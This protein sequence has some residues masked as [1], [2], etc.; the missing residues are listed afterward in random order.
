MCHA[1]LDG[2]TAQDGNC[3]VSMQAH[4]L[5]SVVLELVGDVLA[6]A[7]ADAEIR[8]SLRSIWI[9]LS[10]PNDDGTRRRTAELEKVTAEAKT[11]LARAAGMLVDGN[12]DKLGYEAVRDQILADVEAANAELA[13]LRGKEVP[14]SLPDLDTV[15]RAV[16]SWHRE[17]RAADVGAQ[18]D[19][20]APIVD[21]IV[22]RR[23]GWGKYEAD[24]AWSPLGESL[25]ALAQAAR[26]NRSS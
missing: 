2:A 18:R 17:L 16:E 10:R 1:P 14:T 19:V 9:A 25:H 15:L 11:R 21:R 20:L 24:V 26:L 7:D 13:R 6:V 12:L 3:T 5:D 22:P 8:A 4:I 23:V